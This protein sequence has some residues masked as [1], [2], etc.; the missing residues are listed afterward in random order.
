MLG[1]EEVKLVIAFF[2][3]HQIG[4]ELASISGDELRRKLHDVKL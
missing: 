4:E 1:T 2:F 3:F